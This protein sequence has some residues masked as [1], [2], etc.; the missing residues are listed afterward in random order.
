[1]FD[2]AADR[3]VSNTMYELTAVTWRL[4]Q[5]TKALKRSKAPPHIITAV[6]NM[7]ASLREANHLFLQQ[8]YFH[9]EPVGDDQG[10]LNFP[11]TSNDL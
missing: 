9:V 10:Q 4:K 7:I 5:E 2:S 3:V 8:T 11:Q 6:E 1:M